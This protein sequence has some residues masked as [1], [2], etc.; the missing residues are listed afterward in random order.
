MKKI[1]KIFFL[2]ILLTMTY[3]QIKKIFVVLVLLSFAYPLMTAQALGVNLYES[4]RIGEYVDGGRNIDMRASMIGANENTVNNASSESNEVVNG[5]GMLIEIGNTTAPNT[6]IV[7][8]IAT[9]VGATED[10][11]FE[12]DSNTKIMTSGNL[13]ANLS[14]WI[15]GDSISFTARHYINSDALLATKLSNNSFK[16]A[17]KA[18]N[19]WIKSIN[20]D[21]KTVEVTWADDVFT[22]NIANANMVAGKKNPADI[23]DLQIGDRIR[24]RVIEDNDSNRLTWDASILVIL[25]RGDDLFMK[26]TRWIIPATITM[27]PTNLSVPFTM[28][29]SLSNSNLFHRNDVNNLIG[30]PG[31]KVMIDVNADTMLVRQYYGKALLSELSEGDSIRVI[32]KRDEVTGH[33]VA[34]VIKNTS[35]QRLGMAHRWG[36]VTNIDRNVKTLTIALSQTDESSKTWTITANSS[37]T[38]Y[39]NGSLGTWDDI[40]V[41]SSVRIRGTANTNSS[42]VKADTIIVIN[43]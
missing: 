24:A 27:L 19:G 16:N 26:I 20:T 40:S 38:I 8:R 39:V 14:D 43:E 25:R 7:I 12:I 2:L 10:R 42:T 41:G 4:M 21:N 32:G 31:N 13:R 33:I 23:Y 18:I 22:L 11:V 34:R 37:T 17:H 30:V 28:E 15:A 1:K 3:R 35:I 6:T 36:S 9:Q 5:N 29:V